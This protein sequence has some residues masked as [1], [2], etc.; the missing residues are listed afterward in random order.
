[1]I[2]SK[3]TLCNRS[4][5]SRL[6]YSVRA[7]PPNAFTE[8]SLVNRIAVGTRYIGVVVERQQMLTLFSQQRC[9]QQS[10]WSCRSRWPLYCS[11]SRQSLLCYAKFVV[12]LSIRWTSFSYLQSLPYLLVEHKIQLSITTAVR[13]LYLYIFFSFVQHQKCVQG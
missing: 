6:T 12:Q 1:M 8:P 9:T 2:C 5:S 3:Y 13:P 10:S 11:K 4:S 7:S